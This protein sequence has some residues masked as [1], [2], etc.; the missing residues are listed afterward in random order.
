MATRPP[1]VDPYCAFK[2]DRW[3]FVALL[4]RDLRL[5]IIAM[6]CA[7]IGNGYVQWGNVLRWFGIAA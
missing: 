4:C 1:K 3:R 7:A 5:T 6:T 2:E